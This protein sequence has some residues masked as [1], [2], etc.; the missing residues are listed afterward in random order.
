[1]MSLLPHEYDEI[2][3]KKKSSDCN[4]SANNC[5]VSTRFSP[6][7]SVPL[8]NKSEIM[9]SHGSISGICLLSTNQFG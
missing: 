5:S 6:L 7:D 2:Q 1:M 8:T 3:M 9:R 4:N